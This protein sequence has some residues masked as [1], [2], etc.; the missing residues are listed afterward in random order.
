MVNAFQYSAAAL[1][2][3]MRLLMLSAPL[4]LRA[5]VRLKQLIEVAI[6][7]F[8]GPFV[9]SLIMLKIWRGIMSWSGGSFDRFGRAWIIIKSAYYGLIG[10]GVAHLFRPEQENPICSILLVVSLISLISLNLIRTRC[11]ADVHYT[12]LDWCITKI[13][14]GLSRLFPYTPLDVPLPLFPPVVLP[15]NSDVKL[16]TDLDDLS[17]RTGTG[18][19]RTFSWNGYSE[20]IQ[21]VAEKVELDVYGFT[22]PPEKW[23]EQRSG[24][25]WKEHG[26]VARCIYT[27]GVRN[28]ESA[29]QAL[30]WLQKLK[31]QNCPMVYND[32]GLLI[33]WSKQSG[34][35]TFAAEVWQILIDSQKP[36]S[37]PGSSNDAISIQPSVQTPCS[38]I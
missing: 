25:V 7:S 35:R 12:S 14:Y 2:Q 16:L 9:V 1:P 29:Q 5:T 36:N 10:L 17:I 28:F 11:P 23:T 3:T 27:E 6:L 22:F 8:L 13:G 4:H 37:L 21:L 18:S 31:Q 33:I 30:E 26:N 19:L 32:Q 24:D 20:S 38:Q 15:P 34:F